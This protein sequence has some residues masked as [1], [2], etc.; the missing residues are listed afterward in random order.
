M[1]KLVQAL[2]D[3]PG[4]YRAARHRGRRW[5]GRG[6]GLQKGMDGS[7]TAA[8]RHSPPGRGSA[9][10]LHRLLIRQLRSGSRRRNDCGVQF[11]KPPLAQCIKNVGAPSNRLGRCNR[12]AEPSL[13]HVRCR[14]CSSGLGG[15]VHAQAPAA[16]YPHAGNSRHSSHRHSK[17][18]IV[19]P[20]RRSPKMRRRAISTPTSSG[21]ERSSARRCAD[22]GAGVDGHERIPPHTGGQADDEPGSPPV[23]RDSAIRS[24]NSIRRGIAAFCRCAGADLR[25]RIAQ[26]PHHRWQRQSSPSRG[27]R[28]PWRHDCS[29]R[30]IDHRSGWARHRCRLSGLGAGLHRRAQ[31]WARR[32]FPV[33]HRR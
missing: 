16:D 5:R 14:R 23:A 25:S 24:H 8:E 3:R 29:H 32:H 19:P 31:S 26:C 33:A 20:T 4:S 12:R 17:R 11:G 22:D 6:L 30:A 7:K 13:R 2:V 10:T 18:S 28:D 27:H 21:R 1:S 9:R 15:G